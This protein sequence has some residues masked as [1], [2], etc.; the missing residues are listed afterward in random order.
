MEDYCR[1]LAKEGHVLYI[2]CGPA[3]V[4][5]EGKNGRKDEIGPAR[6]RV[7][8]KSGLP[9]KR[10]RACAATFGPFCPLAVSVKLA[11]GQPF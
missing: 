9:Q 10:E 8:G 2:A 7:T 4:G 1:H 5:G 6:L 11:A 3:G